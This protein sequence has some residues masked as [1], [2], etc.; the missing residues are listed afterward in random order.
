MDGSKVRGAVRSRFTPQPKR[1]CA[2][3]ARRANCCAT[4]SAPRHVARQIQ[5][6]YF[7]VAR[8]LQLALRQLLISGF[9][10]RYYLPA[11]PYG[12]QAIYSMRRSAVRSV[13]KR[14]EMELP[15]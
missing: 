14:L 2:R 11:A 1:A 8:A 12:A 10:R 6:L 13:A 9:V 4:C 7:H 3:G 5:S 15:E